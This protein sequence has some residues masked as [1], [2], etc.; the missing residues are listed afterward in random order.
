MP[1]SGVKEPLMLTLSRG[2]RGLAPAV[3][4]VLLLA[5][6]GEASATVLSRDGGKRLT[7]KSTAAVSNVL[8]VNYNEPSRCSIFA[9]CDPTYAFLDTQEPVTVLADGCKP[10][11]A[12]P[13]NTTI[14]CTAD[15]VTPVGELA[16][17]AG[18]GSDSVQH[19]IDECGI[20]ICRFNPEVPVPMTLTGGDGDDTLVGSSANDTLDGGAGQDTLS[21]QAGTDSLSGGAGN[22][23]LTPGPGDDNT[24]DGG[25]DFDTVSYDDGR[26]SGVTV[27]L[28]DGVAGNDGG[29]DD[30]A[31]GSR[32]ALTGTENVIGTAQGDTLTGDGAFNTIS[33][34]GGDDAIRGGVGQDSLD[35]EGG[36]DTVDYGDHA[37]AVTVT[38]DTS[39]SFKNGS[40]GEFDRTSAFEAVKGGAGGD[41]LISAY[42]AGNPVRLE[43]ELGN[44]TLTGGA[45]DDTLVGGAG[46]DV[47][48]G[49][50]GTDTA[51]YPVAD[52]VVVTLNNGSAKDDGGPDDGAAGARDSVST[53]NVTGG[54]GNDVLIG[55]GGANR[56]RGGDG[57]DSVQGGLGTDDLGGGAGR[58]EASYEERASS[59]PVE[60]SID[61]LVND[62][63][64][65]ENDVLTPDFE[66]V[67]GGSGADR[68]TAT[69]AAGV[70]LVGNS[71]DDELFAPNGS[72]TVQGGNGDDAITGGDGDDVID[73]G[74]GDDAIDGLGGADQVRG[75][76]GADTIEA[77]DGAVDAVDCGTDSDTALTDPAD[78]RTDCELPAAPAQAATGGG[79][80]SGG[81]GAPASGGAPAVVQQR[82][83]E[84]ILV[85]LGFAFRKSTATFTKF[86][87][88]Q[89]KAVPIGATVSALC[90]A[91]R[92]KKCPAK[93]FKKTNAF[94]TVNLKK[95]VGKKLAAGTRLT[96]TVTK[97]GAF[98]GA[99]KTLTV[100]RKKTP[101][102]GTRCL[103]P[104]A[105]KPVGC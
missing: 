17:E 27:T 40:A 59:Q 79:A 84:R 65:G 60:V 14:V 104:G 49:Q 87:K 54:S 53:E 32:E 91:P 74:L 63:T 12:Q 80:P 67:A 99:V 31:A 36:T 90:S 13:A 48:N 103:P 95:W 23:T 44:D 11:G 57:D 6:A 85:I 50:G 8:V 29:P 39:N 58:D 52:A 24:V 16:I 70:E 46:S 89:V 43:G 97:P 18:P 62:G 55:D 1:T 2:R 64:A 7:W 34:R 4:V 73:G 9:P 20:L 82:D 5:L 77:R 47:V 56:I 3:L 51:L 37:A 71:G 93:S 33:G 101:G 41:T 88:L 72:G 38:L 22:D 83:P 28:N 105:A 45:S 98:I 21:G 35:G 42:P 66:I 69:A 68:L 75:G 25:A 26:G 30:G 100:A 96:V 86:T 15:T 76:A 94:G 81:D 10:G 78:S 19:D 92:G 61:G 102:I